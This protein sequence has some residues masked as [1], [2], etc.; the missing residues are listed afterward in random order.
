MTN[1][2]EKRK[3]QKRFTIISSTLLIGMSIVLG[4]N[5]YFPNLLDMR[6]LFLI[7]V[8]SAHFLF[9]FD[10]KIFNSTLLTVICS[11]ISL[12]L[13]AFGINVVDTDAYTVTIS[14]LPVSSMILMILAI[15]LFGTKLDGFATSMWH[16]MYYLLFFTLSILM[17]LLFYNLALKHL[18][19]YIK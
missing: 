6:L 9:V 2:K 10:Y 19:S 3:L 17:S 5:Y 12:L 1:K 4:I 11:L 15:K 8:F 14:A 16:R 13:I 7:F 18:I